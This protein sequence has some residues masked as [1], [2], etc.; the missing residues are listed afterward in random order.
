MSF[1]P[2]IRRCYEFLYIL[3]LLIRVSEK[4]QNILFCFSKEERSRIF[5]ALVYHLIFLFQSCRLLNTI[6]SFQKFASITESFIHQFLVSFLVSYSPFLGV[7]SL[8]L[9][10]IFCLLG[11]ILGVILNLL[12][13][14]LSFCPPFLSTFSL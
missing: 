4:C 5:I 14:L 12:S 8:A 6:L 2:L 11:V 3:Y 10:I 7:I 13:T 1:V 9:S